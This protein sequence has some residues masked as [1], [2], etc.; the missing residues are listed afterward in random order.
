VTRY[1]RARTA[2]HRPYGKLP[3]TRQVWSLESGHAAD[4]VPAFALQACIVM[5][6]GCRS[7]DGSASPSH[8]LSDVLPKPTPVGDEERHEI[9]DLDV[10]VSGSHGRCLKGSGSGDSRLAYRGL[11]IFRS[12]LIGID[13]GHVLARRKS[14]FIGSMMASLGGP[15][16]RATAV[17]QE[18][19]CAKFPL[20]SHAV[21]RPNPERWFHD[22]QHCIA[23]AFTTPRRP[24]SHVD[25][26]PLQSR[27]HLHTIVH[28]I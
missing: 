2:E 10:S 21:R 13:C 23:R 19:P 5:L 9:L 4:E 1:P 28:R 20:A 27:G 22:D 14:A 17:N 8:I 26:R 18:S 7:S 25:N 15:K 11:V 6:H 12:S 3:P 24:R 16:F